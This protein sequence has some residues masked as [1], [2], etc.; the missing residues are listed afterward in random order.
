MKERKITFGQVHVCP[1]DL[2]FCTTLSTLSCGNLV[3]FFFLFFFRRDKCCS[4]ARNH[5]PSLP[6]YDTSHTVCISEY[7]DPVGSNIAN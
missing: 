3:F 1:E 7:S 4:G 5:V 6:G 2:S